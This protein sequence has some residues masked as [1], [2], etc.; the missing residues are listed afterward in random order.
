MPLPYPHSSFL[1]SGN[2]LMDLLLINFTASYNLWFQGW[3]YKRCLY[4]CSWCIEE[5]ITLTISIPMG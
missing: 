3:S 1:E 4:P 5:A 2:L